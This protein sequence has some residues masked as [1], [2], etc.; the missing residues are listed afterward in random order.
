MGS[1][2]TASAATLGL[3]LGIGGAVAYLAGVQGLREAQ[4]LLRVG[5]PARALVK[6]AAGAGGVRPLL[7]FTTREGAV[8]EV[9]SPVPPS[10][11]RPLA[12]GQEVDLAYDPLDPRQVVVRGRA[13]LGLEY[14][15][16]ALGGAAVLG[17]LALF[18]LL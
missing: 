11:A 6:T 8:L 7:Q 12:D 16:L 17:A 4:R 13:R 5:V 2:G 1:V 15:F 3:F 10:R 9:Y 18:A 14:A